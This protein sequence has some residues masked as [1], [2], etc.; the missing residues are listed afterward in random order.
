DAVVIPGL[1]AAETAL[2][3]RGRDDLHSLTPQHRAA[4]GFDPYADYHNALS[5]GV[6]TAQLS[7]GGRRLMP[8]Q[9]AVVKLFGDDP[10]K[11]MLRDDESLR[12]VLGEAF[13]SPPR[14][15]EPPVGAVSVDKPL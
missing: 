9:G 6:T 14:V 3:E 1:I 5:G 8:G 4:D 13:K 7:P 11:R 10:T 15:Y 12:V 2:A